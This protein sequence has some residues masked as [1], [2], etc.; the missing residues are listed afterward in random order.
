MKD[1][2]KGLAKKDITLTDMQVMMTAMQA[3]NEAMGKRVRI[4][5]KLGK[6]VVLENCF[7]V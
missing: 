4:W 5:E 1:L 3:V 7:P 2:A 6:G